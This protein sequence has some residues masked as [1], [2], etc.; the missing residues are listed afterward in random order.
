MTISIGDALLK[1]GVDTANF[2]SGMKA[3]EKQAADAA[4]DISDSFGKIGLAALTIGGAMTAAMGTMANAALDEEINVKRLATTMNNV[5]VSY[6]NVRESL[7]K[8]IA[9]TQRKTGVADD[10]Q[11]DI[12]NRLILTTGDYAKSL[13][14]LPTVLDLAAA[15]EMDAT[16]AA[17]YLGKAFLDL[18]VGAET[19][20]VR[21]GQASLQFKSMDEIQRRVK[22]SAESL[23]NPLNVLKA[24]VGDLAEVLG[25]VLLSEVKK[26][27]DIF[28]DIAIKTKEWTE[29][30]PVLT[31]V[32]VKVTAALGLLLLGLGTYVT[33]M[34]SAT[35]QTTLLTAAK[36][37][38]TVATVA[39]NAAW[40]V[41][42]FVLHG[43]TAGM[44]AFNLAMAANPIAL[45]VIAITALVAAL[46]W[47]IYKY[48]ESSQRIGGD[49]KA[50][51]A[52]IKA[53]LAAQKSAK[54]AALTASGN[55][56][57]TAH[58]KAVQLIKEEYGLAKVAAQNKKD[59][60][61][62][63]S[64]VAQENLDKEL[65]AARR[66]HDDKI[67]LLDDEYDAKMR[68]I[69]AETES[70]TKGIQSRID[71]IEKERDAKDLALQHQQERQR[72][73][74]DQTALNQAR[75]YEERV[76]ATR[77]LNDDIAA[78][79]R[80]HEIDDE[81]AQK[82]ALRDEIT[83]IRNAAIDK[84]TALTDELREKKRNQDSILEAVTTRVAD[85]KAALDTK[86]VED[87]ARITLAGETAIQYQDGILSAT[88]ER[89]AQEEKA[90]AES[91]ARQ[92]TAAALHAEAMRR[93]AAGAVSSAFSGGGGT[94]PQ[95][96]P[97]V[98]T[99]PEFAHGGMITEP[100]LLYGMKSMR[101]YA[102]AGE[103][104]PEP[105]GGVGTVSITGNNFYVR[106]EMDIDRIGQAIVDKIRARTGVKI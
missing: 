1:L 8:V 5:G 29:A 97:P 103:A 67:R 28:V 55:A 40:V 21:F 98:L 63:A 41:S 25:A 76:A 36:L 44:I 59:L 92:E 15:G 81:N 38:H 12:L 49:E 100:T 45:V 84:A 73:F 3:I 102:I 89:L 64:Q 57:Q 70:L 24:S 66:V 53:E 51:T 50:L 35:V 14:L 82:N 77:K 99:L 88:K 105:V 19:V 83:A 58:D 20:S 39:M 34:R 11:R 27:I 93:I 23:V 68:V 37:A 95:P 33:L 30:N 2:D 61:K 10:K 43:A 32:I 47:L 69:N 78:I 22:G 18:Q 79:A 16:T 42:T 56:A 106:S 86:L 90:L 60:A 4:K 104:G 75:T 13:E 74:D 96:P 48:R 101:P 80:Q 6:D 46:G 72:I 17:T 71:K 62:Q 9:T 31:N 7:E 85:E 26:L 94:A 91:F 54:L 65:T 87:L 52:T